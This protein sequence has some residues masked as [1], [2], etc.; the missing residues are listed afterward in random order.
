MDLEEKA[1]RAPMGMM[2][3]VRGVALEPSLIRHLLVSDVSNG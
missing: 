1:D 2:S 3:E